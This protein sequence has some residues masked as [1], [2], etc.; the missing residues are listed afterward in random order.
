MA[1]TAP[2]AGDKISDTW[3]T[4]MTDAANLTQSRGVMVTPVATATA[5]TATSG[6]TET[7][8]AILG[9]YA[10]TALT[11]RRY[12]VVFAGALLNGDTANDRYTLNI[13]DG[14]ASTPTAV[15]TIIVA[16]SRLVAVTGTNGRSGV[17]L[18]GTFT[19]TAGTHTLAIFLLRSAGA[20]IGT[21]V[22]QR[23]I[24]VEDIGNV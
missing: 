15:S 1:I 13:R 24:Y 20:G 5:G 14:G 10:F 11:G 23:E 3:T 17:D 16:T 8:D 21:L 19:A 2:H 12:R 9:N 7:R 4:A 6:T 22:G 18:T